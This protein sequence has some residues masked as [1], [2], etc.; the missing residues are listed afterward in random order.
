M[1]GTVSR[2]PK[3]APVEH[4]PPLPQSSFELSMS[5]ESQP[6]RSRCHDPYAS[7]GCFSQPSVPRS[8]LC[9]YYRRSPA[10]HK[11]RDAKI[12]MAPARGGPRAAGWPRSSEAASKPGG[13]ENGARRGGMPRPRDSP[14]GG[15]A[16]G[17]GSIAARQLVRTDSP[18]VS[19]RN[20]QQGRRSQGL[21]EVCTR[22]SSAP[23]LTLETRVED[24]GAEDHLHAAACGPLETKEPVARDYIPRAIR[25]AGE[26][27]GRVS[28]EAWVRGLVL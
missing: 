26:S 3:L 19:A 25:R 17:R 22:P 20:Q 27:S 8:S 10:Q 6:A 23:R 5:R 16:A 12:H 1:E 15:G 13:D 4:P 9:G 14:R 11:L 28:E 24:I 2:P 18:G 21:G 7:V